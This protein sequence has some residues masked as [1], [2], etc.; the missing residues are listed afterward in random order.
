M[1]VSERLQMPPLD[2]AA[3]W[4]NSESL[5]PAEPRGHVVVVNFWTLTCVNWL[6]QV[7]CVRA[8]HRPIAT[9]GWS[10]SA[11]TPRSSPSNT[12]PT[13]CGARRTSERSTIAA[14]RRALQRRLRELGD[15][16]RDMSAR[17]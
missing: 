1:A 7:P 9:T 3:E 14:G 12:V 11:S 16:K 13:A 5:G 8:C 15:R 17:E 2:G 4:L 6:R 10:S